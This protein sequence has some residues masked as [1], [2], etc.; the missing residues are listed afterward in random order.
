MHEQPN[1]AIEAGSRSTAT[2]V[3]GIRQKV[4][5]VAQGATGV[6][7]AMVDNITIRLELS[8]A[9]SLDNVERRLLKE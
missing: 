9:T 6:F 1:P 4:M 3:Y 7:G 8:A 2:S 5:T